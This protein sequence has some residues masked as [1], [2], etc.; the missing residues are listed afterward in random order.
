MLIAGAAENEGVCRS[1]ST[2]SASVRRLPHRHREAPPRRG[3]RRG[4]RG[5]AG[6]VATLVGVEAE[7]RGVE[8]IA[9]GDDV[10]RSGVCGV[11]A[12]CRRIGHGSV[13]HVSD[14]DR[15]AAIANGDALL[16]SRHRDRLHVERDHRLLPCRRQAVRCRSRGARRVRRCRRG[17]RA[18]CERPRLVP[19]RAVRRARGARSGVARRKGPR[20]MKVHAIVD[21][22]ETAERAVSA[23]ATV[24]QLRVKAPTAV[25]VERGQG[26]TGLGVT[27]IV[28]DGV[29]AAILLDADGVHLVQ[30]T[31]TR[32]VPGPRPVGRPL[33]RDGR[34]GARGRRGLSRRGPV[35][36]TPSKADAEPPMGS[37]ACA[38]SAPPST[39]P[40]S[41]SEVSTHRRRRLHRVGRAGV[42][43][44]RAAT[45]RLRRA[46]EEALGNG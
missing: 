14:G 45:D 29:E 3:G 19:R 7:V 13:D 17:R 24:V 38:G 39:S 20:R 28:K 10:P 9:A 23:G 15:V 34:A 37:R 43:V 11:R 40:S 44:I 16:A 26:F 25:V 35:R 30:T 27:F 2:R 21:G 6:E 22:L 42:A 12:G 32:S 46:V 8:S 36:A 18:C 41:R 1:F 31:R 33:G 4:M 5:N